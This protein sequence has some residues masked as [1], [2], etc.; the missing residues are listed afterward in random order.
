MND[1]TIS[2]DKTSASDSDNSNRIKQANAEIRVL[3]RYFELAPNS[4]MT[5][6]EKYLQDLKKHPAANDPDDSN[7]E[8]VNKKIEATSFNL[9]LIPRPEDYPKNQ[10][11]YTDRYIAAKN[12]LETYAR[13]TKEIDAIQQTDQS[14]EASAEAIS[15][16]GQ[17]EKLP[18]IKPEDFAASTPKIIASDKTVP[19][20][21]EILFTLNG[22]YEGVS[23]FWLFGNYQSDDRQLSRTD[24]LVVNTTDLEV[25]KQYRV[26]ATLTSKKREQKYVEAFFTVDAAI[27]IPEFENAE[28]TVKK[29]PQSVQLLA[30]FTE[31]ARGFYSWVVDS[32]TS[33]FREVT[34]GVAIS[35]LQL[36][37]LMAGQYR[38]RVS[39]SYQGETRRLEAHFDIADDNTNTATPGLQ[40]RDDFIA[41]AATLFASTGNFDQDKVHNAILGYLLTVDYREERLAADDPKRAAYYA[42]RPS[43]GF[44][45]TSHPLYLVRSHQDLE[46]VKSSDFFIRDFM[47]LQGRGGSEASPYII[48][49]NR[50]VGN[51]RN[52]LSIID[53]VMESSFANDFNTLVEAINAS[54]LVQQRAGRVKFFSHIAHRDAIQLIPYSGDVSQFAGVTMRNII[55]NGNSIASDAALQG[56]FASDG[57]FQNLH[58]T[59][60]SIQTAGAHTISISGML[61]GTIDGNT[62]LQGELLPADAITLYPLRIGGGANIYV[63]SFY[64]P[65]GI[66][67]GDA[68]YYA[69][70]EI[71]G[72]Q[73][74]N[75]RRQ[76]KDHANAS[77][78][79]N[80][81]L[82]AL[83]SR[84]EATYSQ[85]KQLKIDRNTT[86]AQ[87]REDNRP[88]ADIR[89]AAD[90]YQANIDAAWNDMMHQVG[91]P[92]E[93]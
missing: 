53:G 24:Y 51:Q 44:D 6:L 50:S 92:D 17:C 18:I 52:G 9:N 43:D 35:H 89:A 30:P 49:D 77:Y 34:H 46:N 64:N 69:Y 10:K 57:S 78:W 93:S 20:G 60:N 41:E 70:E 23:C 63:M 56:I 37:D 2:R 12:I 47:Q 33:T 48:G 29:Q 8:T 5:V 87:L 27:T 71:A 54:D 55:I 59:N 13:R 21:G 66:T 91:E 67:Q 80:V 61:S 3:S 22:V 72:D 11:S 4:D 32:S 75:D 85:V 83:Q 58:I 14:L 36:E 86:L 90:E 76:K 38:A 65:D 79:K 26:R 45:Y 82:P 74:I 7:Y 42:T 19:V 84:F 28:I 73:A 39:I 40:S 1:T 25:G 88:Y 68:D 31:E 81:N 16:A 15:D 62:D